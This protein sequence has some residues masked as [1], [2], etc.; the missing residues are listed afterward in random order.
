MLVVSTKL[1]NVGPG[2]YLGDCQQA[3]KPSRYVTSHSA[4]LSL[5]IS[6]WVGTM[7][8]GE[9][10]DINWHTGWCTSPVSLVWQCKLVSGWEL[11]KWRL[12]LSYGPYGLG[13]TVLYFMSA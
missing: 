13:R 3:G 10:W 8:T 2:W 7:N 1:I 12:P 4:Q 11:R 9:S 6:S 5:A